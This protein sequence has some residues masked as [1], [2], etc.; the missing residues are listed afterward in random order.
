MIRIGVGFILLLVVVLPWGGYLLGARHGRRLERRWVH[1]VQPVL[2]FR[3][4]ELQG[5]ED[6][7]ALALEDVRARADIELQDREERYLQLEEG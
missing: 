5:S 6:A 3:Q 4:L 1:I 7:A 2:R